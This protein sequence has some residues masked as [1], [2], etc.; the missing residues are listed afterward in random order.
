MGLTLNLALVFAYVC[1]QKTRM[2]GQSARTRN[3]GLSC[4]PIYC[5][6]ALFL[7]LLRPCGGSDVSESSP[8]QFQTNIHPFIVVVKPQNSDWVGQQLRD[9][10]DSSGT[11]CPSPDELQE[12]PEALLIFQKLF[13]DLEL[14]SAWL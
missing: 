5:A 9:M 8:F 7:I 1:E 3:L 10:L 13:G 14:H 2:L 4:V 12:L 11:C 6:L